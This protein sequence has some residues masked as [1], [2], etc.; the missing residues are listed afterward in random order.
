MLSQV[1]TCYLFCHNDGWLHNTRILS[2]GSPADQLQ[3]TLS[4]C[5]DE[6][7]Y[8][9]QSNRLQ[10]NTVKT[11]ILWCSTTCRQN[12][13]PSAAA[14]VGENHVLPLTS[15]RDLGIHIDSDVRMRSH[16][17]ITV[18]GCF[19]VLRQPRSIRRSVSDSVFHSWS[20]HISTMATQHLLGLPRPSSVD[21]SWCSTPPPD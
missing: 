10:L 14:R 17:S 18:S 15:V 19:D 6:V 2:Y 16:V 7:S 12:D 21:F 8:W 1:I 13:L 4:A 9:M 20:C 5:L 3:S 11:E